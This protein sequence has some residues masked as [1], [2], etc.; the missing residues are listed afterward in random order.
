MSNC[1]SLLQ[2][3][4]LGWVE[5][6][7]ADQEVTTYPVLALILKLLFVLADLPLQPMDLLGELC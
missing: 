5:R 1:V 7:T 6:L 2:G 3:E 4:E